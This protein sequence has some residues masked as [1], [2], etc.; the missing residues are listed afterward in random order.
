MSK[1]IFGFLGS[2]PQK[3]NND[4]WEHWKKFF[5][6]QHVN[7]NNIYI[8]LH[9]FHIDR[10]AYLEQY[11]KRQM[12]I[13]CRNALTKLQENGHFICKLTDTLTRFT[14]GL[15]FRLYFFAKSKSL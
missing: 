14:T 1:V 10:G 11:N 7:K 15:I 3:K 9:P 4:N 2:L 8:L 6:M 13:S 12:L 5:N